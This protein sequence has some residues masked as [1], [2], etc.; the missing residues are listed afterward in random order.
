MFCKS[1]NSTHVDERLEAL[2]TNPDNTYG[3]QIGKK[4]VMQEIAYQINLTNEN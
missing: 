3:H 1:Y 2:E 4:Q